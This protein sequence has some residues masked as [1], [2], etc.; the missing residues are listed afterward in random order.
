MLDPRTCKNPIE[1][2][3]EAAAPTL[4]TA[5]ASRT[6]AARHVRVRAILRVLLT[7]GREKEIRRPAVGHP[8]SGDSSQNNGAGLDVLLVATPSQPVW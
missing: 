2:N 7:G 8:V 1:I 5:P 3:R 6:R 4:L